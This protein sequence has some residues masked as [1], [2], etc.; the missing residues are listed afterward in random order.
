MKI[1]GI[2]AHYHD[3]AA[4]LLIDGAPDKVENWRPNKWGTGA[5]AVSRIFGPVLVKRSIGSWNGRLLYLEVWPL[6]N[7]AATGIEYIVEASFKTKSHK[8]ASREQANL[9][10]YLQSKGW[11]LTQDSLKTQLIME[12]Y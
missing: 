5:L 8:K 3:S 12:R 2:S 7:S 9:A 1:L 6:L 4:A 10:T 11:L